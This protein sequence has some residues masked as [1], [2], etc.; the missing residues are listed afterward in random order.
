MLKKAMV[1][2]FAL[3]SLSLHAASFEVADQLYM[4]REG[5]V[6]NTQAARAAY[7]TL[8]DSGLTGSDLERAVLGVARTYVYEG[9]VL[10]G[11]VSDEDIASRRSIFRSCWRDTMPAIE[12]AKLGYSS[13]GYYYYTAACI[14]LFGEVSGTLENLGNIP[15]LLSAIN[16]GLEVEGG[17][18][19]EGG[20]LYRVYAAV[21]SNEKAKPL[22][23]N[24]YN[25][26][27]ALELIDQAIN[28]PAYPGGSEGFLYCENYRRK[29]MVL[30]E[31]GRGD[32][33]LDLALMTIDDFEL[34]LD[35]EEV[36]LPI[37]PETKHCLNLLQDFVEKF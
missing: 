12:P 24:L 22:P 8:I 13:P 7:Q 9:E 33:A 21:K 31:L 37:V 32:E 20:G 30:D 26:Q 3:G 25:P 36:P 35:L 1:A 14:A 27:E 10:T 17:D 15:R 23:G 19:I 6:E 4:E 18:T 5:S 28:A 2:A 34:F 29:A 16:R 11:R